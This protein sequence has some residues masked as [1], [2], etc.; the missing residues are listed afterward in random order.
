MYFFDVVIMLISY[1]VVI[2]VLIFIIKIIYSLYIFFELVRIV[3][4]KNNAEQASSQ[5]P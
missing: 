1:R 5:M 2:A 3:H 4:E